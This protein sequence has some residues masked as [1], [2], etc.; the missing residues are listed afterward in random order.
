M[1]V[2]PVTGAHPEPADAPAELP[3]DDIVTEVYDHNV[4]TWESV[5]Q[6]IDADEI[7]RQARDLEHHLEWARATHQI[8]RLFW[9]EDLLDRIRGRRVLEIGG[10]DG[11]TAV[12]LLKLGAAHVTVQEIT[13][14]T[15]RVVKDCL[16]ELDI[17]GTVEVRIGNPLE[18]D[19]GDP[20]DVVIA[21]R[22]LHHIPTPIEDEFVGML[23]NATADDGWLRITDPAVNGRR[24]DALRWMLPAS[25]RPSRLSKKKFA[26]WKAQDPHPDRDNST[27]HAESLFRRHFREVHSETTGGVSRLH[28]WVDSEK[29]HDSAQRALNVI[30]SKIP[31]GIQRWMAA[32][33]S[34][35]A[36]G[37]I[38]R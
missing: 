5:Y 27:K 3:G 34:I 15:E 32:G 4:I 8:E 19:L 31:D 18:I 14:A 29:Y 25:G 37:P 11:R 16:R 26:A 28:R 2:D 21:R 17:E 35:T 12:F 13:P 24:L 6:E 36:S 9:D 30:D 23:A 10:G 20:Y 33:H 38:R 7:V 1:Q 22:V